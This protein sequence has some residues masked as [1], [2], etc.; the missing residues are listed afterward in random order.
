[1]LRIILRESSLHLLY[2]W[3]V[4]NGTTPFTLGNHILGIVASYNPFRKG[5][6]DYRL[7]CCPTKYQL[8][9]KVNGSTTTN[10]QKIITNTGT[11]TESKNLTIFLF[12]EPKANNQPTTTN[13]HQQTIQQVLWAALIHDLDIVSWVGDVGRGIGNKVGL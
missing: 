5:F 4:R 12:S 2:I 8:E 3:K 13:N 9:V 1:M 10:K 11:Y 6:C 7:G